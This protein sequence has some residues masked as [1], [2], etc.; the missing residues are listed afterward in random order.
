M[1]EIK[2]GAEAKHAVEGF[3]KGKVKAFI[4]GAAKM[5][6]EKLSNH[7]CNGN[8]VSYLAQSMI[9]ISA[10]V[11]GTAVAS[12]PLTIAGGV[13]GIDTVVSMARG[14][15]PLLEKLANTPKD[16][17][18]LVNKAIEKGGR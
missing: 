18:N 14:K 10:S 13:L 15:T 8:D 9:A 12:A 3:T 17:K 6:D 2:K 5:L 1:S 16:I 4:C 7:S 11:V